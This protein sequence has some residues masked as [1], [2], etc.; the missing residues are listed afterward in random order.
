MSKQ[1]RLCLRCE[2]VRCDR[3]VGG[4]GVATP[5][6]KKILEEKGTEIFWFILALRHKM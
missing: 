6:L 4:R 5:N 3:S 2:L 1:N